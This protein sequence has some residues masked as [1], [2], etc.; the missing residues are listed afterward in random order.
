MKSPDE[1]VKTVDEPD[2]VGPP[3]PPT[4]LA[5]RSRDFRATCQDK[6]WPITCLFGALASTATVTSAFGE[7]I[8]DNRFEQFSNPARRIAKTFTLW[9]G[10]RGLGRVREDFWP[11][12]TAP[13]AILRGLGLSPVLA[14]KLWLA[15]VLVVLGIGTV[16]VLRLF[17]PSIGLA[18]VV[19]GL[20][21]M[22]GAYSATF[23]VPSNLAF[24]AAL[25]P[26]FIVALWR[27]VTGTRPW[28]W[29]A[30][31][32]LLVFVAGN[33]DI[34]GLMYAM[35][36]LVPVTAYLLVVERSVRVR[37]LAAWLARAGL[38][39]LL[40]S[41]AALAKT[42]AAATSL[43]QRLAETESPR[44]SST[45]SS[46]SESFRGL[47]NWLSYFQQS[48]VAE[49][50]QGEPYLVNPVVVLATFVP[51]IVGLAVIWR[52]QWRPRILFIWMAVC[53]L[54]VMVEAYPLTSPSPVGSLI[55]DLVTN[56]TNLR[57]FRNTYKAGVGLTVGVAVLFGVG[58]AAA[59]QWVGPARVAARRAV[60][61]AVLLI[62]LAGAVPFWTGGLFDGN[63]AMTQVPDYWNQAFSYLDA[64]P[65]D[66][67]VLVLPSSSRTHYRWGWVGD[68][69]FDAMLTK[70]H[71]VATG[72]PL[73]TPLPANLI[74]AV[75]AY[76]SDPTYQVGTL[77]PILRRLGINE[78]VLRNDLDWQE[79]GRPRPALYA[80]LRADPGFRLVAAFG[81]PGENTTSAKD[82][83]ADATFER[84]I[85]P[86]EIYQLSDALPGLRAAAPE[87]SMLVSGD[88]AAW[89]TLAATG[90]LAGTAPIQYSGSLGASAI[91]AA[92]VGGSPLLVT[93][94]NRRRLRV[95]V[96]HDPD[97]SYLLSEAQ[98]LDRPTQSL[99]PDPATQSRA[100]FPDATSISLS[101]NPRGITG[102]APWNQPTK[103]F[104]GDPAT[105][106]VMRHDQVPEGRTFRIQLR[107]PHTV[108]RIK[109]DLA[110][111]LTPDSSVR[112]LKLKFSDGPDVLMNL[113]APTSELD[114]GARETSFIDIQILGVSPAAPEVGFAD[115]TFPGLDLR[116]F[117]E[118][119]TDVSDQ[120]QRDESLRAAVTGAPMSFLFARDDTA[121]LGQ[122]TFSRAQADLAQVAEVA[123]LR[124]F[125]SV[126]RR[127]FSMRG[128]LHLNDRVTDAYL[129]TVM[130]PLARGVASARV[131]G[132]SDWGGLA[133]D[134][135]PAT[136]WTGPATAGTSITVQ[137]PSRPVTSVIVETIA[138]AATAR[139]KTVQVE[140]GDQV[141]TADL[142]TEGCTNPSTTCTPSVTVTLPKRTTSGQVKVSVTALDPGGN[143]E[144][145]TYKISE[146]QV[147]GTPNTRLDLTSPLPDE[148]QSVGLTIDGADAPVRLTGTVGDLLAFDRLAWTACSPI[149]L[150]AGPHQLVTADTPSVDRVQ[151]A[152]VDAAPRAA[153]PAATSEVTV[154]SRSPTSVHL[155]V[156]GPGPATLWMGESFDERWVASVDGGPSQEAVAIDTQNG[157]EVARAGTRDV[158][159]R[160]RPARLFENS[161]LVTGATVALCLWLALRPSRRA[162][163]RGSRR[164]ET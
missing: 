91:T 108:D 61:V 111:G 14:Q 39:C 22:F 40:I 116:E 49:K 70:D 15:L 16:A 106:W 52:S 44:I 136:A 118:A 156:S 103:A 31:F 130:G 164:G 112:L 149:T 155:R 41:A 160:F 147:N 101:G 13:L 131:G 21:A 46:W 3:P 97:Y 140:V 6:L 55:L 7:L 68:D 48:N 119:P 114:F 154:V 34:P 109:V 36:P 35:L 9:D 133:A 89:P 134:G 152:T 90:S 150:G 64:Q 138:D 92:L 98:D 105:Q 54:V 5:D 162:R 62:L 60:L 74:E 17:R 115:I 93:D 117:V 45:T 24:Q 126:G 28:R 96:G 4:R 8:R 88:G 75:S 11:G 43:D 20:A 37:D 146:I 76:T 26:W 104:D 27:G 129:A 2:P 158:V 151:M 159:L 121:P 57:A 79:M 84:T 107:S 113:S 153:D 65:A 58:A 139:V 77:A 120:A 42:V 125:T 19:A 81:N 135:D 72:I 47:G 141:V 69:I 23:L 128:A 123:M 127:T 63:R 1:M 144:R 137:V 25:A 110:T 71:A 157:W 38:L 29:A 66:E 32:A 12:T 33:A 86:V 95:L 78:V 148:C 56:V 161:L 53:A 18:H 142:N 10:S 124:R 145:G 102:S 80:G 83:T 51:A 59:A 132:L 67:R 73:S 82:K 100:W 85:P 50:P 163:A 99:F 94:T 122:T 87:P 30:V 143:P